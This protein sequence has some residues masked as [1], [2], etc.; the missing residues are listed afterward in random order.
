VYGRPTD[1]LGSYS[2]TYL[3][4]GTAAL[5]GLC[6]A[7]GAGDYCLM[8]LPTGVTYNSTTKLLT[9][10]FDSNINGDDTKTVV[11]TVQPD[12]VWTGDRAVVVTPQSGST[13]TGGAAATVTIQEALPKV[14]VGAR[15]MRNRQVMPTSQVHASPVG[16]IECWKGGRQGVGYTHSQEL[17]C[18]WNHQERPVLCRAFQG[19][20]WARA[21]LACLHLAAA[22]VSV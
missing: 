7:P 5:A 22:H 3:L 17:S 2:A 6:L 11:G 19:H 16:G 4:G 14:R 8:T 21:G 20:V 18:A 9:A 13:L 12:S 10:T 1:S 15:G